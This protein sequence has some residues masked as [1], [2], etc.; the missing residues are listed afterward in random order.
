MKDNYNC[1]NVQI[2]NNNNMYNTYEAKCEILQ[3][4][5]WTQLEEFLDKRMSELKNDGKNYMI[6]KKSL[7]Y[8]KRRDEKGLRRFIFSNKD[9]FFTNVLSDMASSGLLLALGQLFL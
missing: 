2:G 6:A 4:K 8:S 7:E 3:E 5:Q 9:A 1:N